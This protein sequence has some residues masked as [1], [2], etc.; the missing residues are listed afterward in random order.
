MLNTIYP[1]DDLFGTNV[2]RIPQ[3]QR[4]YSWDEIH[5]K[6]FL[7]DLREQVSAQKENPDKQY[8]LGTFLLHEV[9][10]NGRKF[11]YIVDGQQ[12]L[13]TSV[14]FI[15]CFLDLIDKNAITCKNEKPAYLRRNYIYDAE[16]ETRKFHT[17]KE[18]E[19]YFCSEI[20]RQTST[21]I[22][23][24]SPS[25]IR[26]KAASEFF[27]KE[28]QASEWE[29]L[30]GALRNSSAM[31][32]AVNNSADATQIFEL[33]ND[34]GKKLSDLEALKSYLMHA[35]Y[36]KS[37]HPEEQLENIQTQFA[38]IFRLIEQLSEVARTPDEDSVLTYHCVAFIEWT[39]DPWRNPK[40]L[41]K[42]MIRKIEPEN[43]V[44]WI[45]IFVSELVE[46]YRSIWT[47]YQNRATYEEFS[48]L[49]VMGR[50]APFWPLILKTF[51][52]DNTEDKK[53]FRKACRLMEVY[54]F[55][56]YAISNLRSDSGMT[57]LYTTSRD[58][59]GDFKVL[60]D[61]LSEMCTWY[62]LD[63]R[64]T[65]GLD[66]ARLYLDDK[67]DALYLLWKYENSLRQKPGQT[68]SELSWRKYLEPRDYASKLSI[69]HIAAQSDPISDKTVEWNKGEQAQ[70][71]EVATHRL[72]NLVIDSISTNASKGKKD[73]EGKLKKFT[74]SSTYLSQGELIDYAEVI[75][76]E[77]VWTLESVK[78]RH[79]M[80][81]QFARQN[82]N[83]KTYHTV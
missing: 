20:L 15:A 11:V 48:E 82:W 6:A 47:L 18:D 81:V 71:S 7:D 39:N 36:L 24:T 65:T 61:H 63:V 64:F 58:F 49:V 42:D 9:S 33:Q 54:A 14:V 51:N 60:Y 73:F 79:A 40:Q 45:N 62:N 56:G 78:K 19:P 67:N 69:E 22:T 46:T 12:R 41:I 32:Y 70:F 38:N 76:G 43:I 31:V 80:L 13:T 34:R 29:D 37:N 55:K 4:A 74:Q 57:S 8:F 26:L 83:P 35:I 28:I 5:I 21:K 3:Y 53:E 1:L 30:I 16:K 75:E 50:M 72:G 25:A 77:P 68:Q 52:Y 44:D 10:Q 23:N 17:I 2:F 59:K 66:N 27:R